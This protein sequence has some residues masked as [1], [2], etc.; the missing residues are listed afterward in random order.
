MELWGT[1]PLVIPKEHAW[2]TLLYCIPNK[3]DTQFGSIRPRK[4][5]FYVLAYKQFFC[6][7]THVNIN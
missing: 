3:A 5:L 1:H 2:D 6:E 4:E 7:I